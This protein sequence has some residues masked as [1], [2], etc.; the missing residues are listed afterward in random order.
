PRRR[1]ARELVPSRAST[2]RLPDRLAASGPLERAPHPRDGR[3]RIVVA[4]DHAHSQVQERLS[5]MHEQML[6]IAREVP[7]SA[8]RAVIDFLLAMAR[9]LETE[10][11]PPTLTPREH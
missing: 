9:H 6:E 8:R 10:A 2:W 4:T 3:S 11:T 5:G 7:A 1:P